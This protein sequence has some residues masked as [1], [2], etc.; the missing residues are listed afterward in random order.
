MNSMDQEVEGQEEPWLCLLSVC[1][2][3][4]T[5]PLQRWQESERSLDQRIVRSSQ[6]EMELKA[7][8]HMFTKKFDEKQQYF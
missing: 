2:A 7:L 1:T 5:Q 8:R 4:R 6:Q 3:R